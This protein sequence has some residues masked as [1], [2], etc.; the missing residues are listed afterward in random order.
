MIALREGLRFAIGA[1]VFVFALGGAGECLAA[2]ALTRP[3]FVLNSLDATVSV[4]DPVTFR[5]INRIAVGKEP[6]HLYMTPD[7]K[8][9]LVANALGDSLT[10]IDPATADASDLAMATIVSRNS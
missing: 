5:E 4:I 8:S 2:G 1:F 7:D 3:V 9:L 10:F 6:H